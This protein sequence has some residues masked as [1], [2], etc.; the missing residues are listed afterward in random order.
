MQQI[1]V[2]FKPNTSLEIIDQRIKILLKN[3]NPEDYI[4][5]SMFEYDKFIKVSI[6]KDPKGHLRVVK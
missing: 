2:N 3:F 1:I 5:V 4:I 6:L